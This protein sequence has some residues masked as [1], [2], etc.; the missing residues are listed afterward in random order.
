[1]K[2]CIAKFPLLTTPKPKEELI[3]YLCAAREAVSAVLIRDSQQMPIYFFIRALQAL[4]V[5]YNSMEKLIL[6]LVHASRRGDGGD[7]WRPDDGGDECGGGFDGGSGGGRD[8]N[9]GGCS[10]NGYGG[11]G[12]GVIEEDKFGVGVGD[13]GHGGEGGG[14]SG[15]DGCGGVVSLGMK[16]VVRVASIG[17]MRRWMMMVA[18][19][20]WPEFG[21]IPDP[22]IVLGSRAEGSP[23][24]PSLCDST[25]E[26]ESPLY[27]GI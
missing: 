1:M 16:K 18:G 8:V 21:R 26:S 6:A 9:A 23:F 20:R 3:M 14:G 12:C 22:T 11:V 2:Q 10:G 7:E 27:V 25:L 24:E 17:E 15:R 4:E 19:N 5:N 13:D